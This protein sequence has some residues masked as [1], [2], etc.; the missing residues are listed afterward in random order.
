M[1]SIASYIGGNRPSDR[2]SILN[3]RLVF[4]WPVLLCLSRGTGVWELSSET[5]FLET[6][7]DCD[8]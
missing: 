3:L 4:R 1:V 8:H 7:K 6:E 2:P 5:A